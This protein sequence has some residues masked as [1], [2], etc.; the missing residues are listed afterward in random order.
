MSELIYPGTCI[1]LPKPRQDIKH[2]WVV[3]TKPEGE[4]A[5]VVIVNLTTR[6]QGSDT[7]VVLKPGDHRFIRQETVVNFSDARFDPVGPL[8]KISELVGY[9][10]DDDC[11]DE[12]LQRIREG[13]LHSPFTPK[14]ILA[15]CKSRF[16]G[17]ASD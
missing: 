13:L 1:L 15:Y 9:E 6:R 11:S 10:F 4:P 16:T 8:E 2:L 7:T 17:L 12:L 3:L 14:N 5:Q